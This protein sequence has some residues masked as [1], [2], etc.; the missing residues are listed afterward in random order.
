LVNSVVV[1]LHRT[2]GEVVVAR[3]VFDVAVLTCAPEGVTAVALGALEAQFRAHLL[4]LCAVVEAGELTRSPD[5]E[6]GFGL[7][8]HTKGVRPGLEWMPASEREARVL[9][10]AAAVPLK[11]ADASSTT[12]VIASR[13]EAHAC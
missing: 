4:R 1:A 2:A 8:L 11:D 13:L 6:L 9:D 5:G 12:A 7:V 3:Y 10:G